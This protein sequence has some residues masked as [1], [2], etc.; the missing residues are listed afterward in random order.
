MDLEH[1]EVLSTV[2][3]EKPKNVV[4]I[5]EAA[6]INGVT[7]QA[8]YVA[9]KQGKLKACKDDARWTIKL[10]DLETYRRNK[11]SRSKSTYEGELLFDNEKGY[12]SINQTAKML[13][14]PPQKVY[15]ATRIGIL[16]A[17]RKGSAWVLRAEDIEEYKERYLAKSTF[18][19]EAL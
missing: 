9:I 8:I 18:E 1:T 10:D 16:K 19:T 2:S 11:Y 4:S 14:I 5:T 17:S 6:N 13:K 3:E 7:R 12:Y 15:Y